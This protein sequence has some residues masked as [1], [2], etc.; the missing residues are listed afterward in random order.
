MRP[1]AWLLIVLAPAFLVG[2]AIH[3]VAELLYLKTGVRMLDLVVIRQEGDLGH[4][5][6]EGGNRPS[7]RANAAVLVGQ[8]V[9]ELETVG[10]FEGAV[11]KRLGHFKA[12]KG[13][14]ILLRILATGDSDDVEA[15]LRA[16][17]SGLVLLVG[18]NRAV[19]FAQLGKLHRCDLIDVRMADGVRRVMRQ[20]AEGEGQFVGCGR[21]TEQRFHEIAGT[22]V[23]Q[24]IR[25]GLAAL[26]VVTE[27][28]DHAATIGVGVG[29]LDLIRCNSRE[30]GLQQRNRVRGPRHIHDL[31]VRQDGVG[32]K[33]GN[34]A[35]EDAETKNRS[36]KKWP[37]WM[38]QFY[39]CREMLGF[40]ETA[41]VRGK[42]AFLIYKR[43]GRPFPLWI[44]T[45]VLFLRSGTCRNRNLGLRQGGLD[46][47]KDRIRVGGSCFVAGDDLVFILGHNHDGGCPGDVQLLAQGV[48]GTNLRGQGT[49]RIDL[50]GEGHLTVGGELLCGAEEVILAGDR[51]LRGE[52]G[53]AVLIGHLGAYL[54]LHPSRI[55]GCIEAPNVHFKRKIV[56]NQGHMVLLD[57][58]MDDR[59]GGGAGGTFQVFKLNNGDTCTSGGLQNGG[60]AKLVGHRRSTELGLRYGRKGRGSYDR[61]SKESR[62]GLHLTPL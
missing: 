26:G 1:E 23:V 40:E 31:F 17:V 11:Q 35:K 55:D 30:A 38:K 42:V 15:K 61:G 60:I 29:L 57:G 46:G 14:V 12:D 44:G 3:A 20:R 41:P 21:S 9:S 56:A 58:T 51:L 48:V 62:K 52:D 33:G 34:A 53:G 32:A 16:Q 10:L 5:R 22:N 4:L 37:H 6:D 28:L 50:E 36:M 8:Q 25:E 24:K 59:R 39:L 43:N 19:L 18:H 49:G 2:R 45:L 54:F 13:A 27:I 7:C 47:G